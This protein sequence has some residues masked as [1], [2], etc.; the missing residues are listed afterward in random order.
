[1][2]MKFIAGISLATVAAASFWACGEGQI[3]ESNDE[4]YMFGLKTPEEW[5]S[6][7][8]QSLEACAKDETCSAMYGDYLADPTA[9]VTEDTPASSANQGGQT[10]L[11]TSSSSRSDGN[12]VISDYSSSSATFVEQDPVVQSSSSA[13]PIVVTGLGSCAPLTNPV[14]KG[15]A[16][17]WKFTPNPASTYKP[18]DF[19]SATYVWD[20]GG[21]SDDGSGSTST[22]G[23]VTYS[24]AGDHTAS[25][26]VTMKDGSSEVK[27]CESLRVNGDPILGCSCKSDQKTPKVDVAEGPVTVNWTVT[28]QTAVTGWAWTGATGTTGTG[29]VV[30][31]DKDIVKPSVT[32]STDESQ[33]LVECDQVEGYDAATFGK[34][35][36]LPFQSQ[37]ALEAGTY[38]LTMTHEGWTGTAM[39]TLTYGTLQISVNNSCTVNLNGVAKTITNNEAI[40]NTDELVL[41]ETP[42]N[43]VTGISAY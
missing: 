30:V 18:M 17:A 31:N 40:K 20:F 8:D 5:A 10:G 34:D 28:C 35:L 33:L 7:K 36:D 24:T 29:S 1:M 4:D 15:T 41:L 3:Y 23:K 25:V 11:Q 22:S 32:V 14:S 21:L 43:C 16:V 38:R 9:D 26:T 27:Q 12:I 37:T 42:A 2:N 39:G 13:A 6:L 19:V